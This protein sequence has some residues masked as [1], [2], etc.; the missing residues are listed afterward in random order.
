MNLTERDQAVIWHP[1]TQ[2]KTSIAPFA[3][4]R[5][6]GA[7]LFD[8]NGKRYLDLI[9][10]WWVNLHGHAHPDIAD[11][12]YRQAQKLEHVIFS[13][14]THEPAIELAE[15]LLKLLPNEFSKVFYSDNGSSAV[16]VALKMAYQYWRNV[17]E[18]K[19]KRFIAF[20]QG[21]H[22]DTFG[23]MAV[24]KKIGFADH[25]EELLFEVDTFPYPGTWLGDLNADDK[26]QKVLQQISQ[27]LEQFGSQT[28]ALIIEPLIQGVGG[29]TMCRPSFLRELERLMKSHQVLIIY[30][31]VMTGFGRTGDFFACNKSNTTPDIICLAKGL[32]GG[33]LPLAVTVCQDKVYQAFLG[34]NF[35]TALAHGHSYTANPLGCAAALESLKLLNRPET[36][37]QIK[38]IEKVHSESLMN[39]ANDMPIEKQRFCGTVSAFDL[40]GATEYGSHFSV[41]LR[42]KFVEQG[43][44]IRPL[45][46]VVYM[47]PPY[48][49]TEQELRSAYEI[50]TEEI[51][52]VI[53]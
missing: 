51:Q 39:F 16:E 23:A 11:A 18:P 14:F 7:Y 3:M 2:H 8:E 49:I 46:N 29:M 43:L 38:T 25:F 48:C 12:I 27:Y 15:K 9:S 13:G 34:D 32:T 28:A 45:G 35:T 31:E 4:T 52:G 50:I 42:E 30:D 17:G 6:E 36:I 41:K 37:M 22:G 53:A 10:S 19:R 47:I 21:Y 33:F 44:I 24:G 26:E 1:F 40:K 20:Q 5:G